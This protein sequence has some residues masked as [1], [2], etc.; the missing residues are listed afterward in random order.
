[1]ALYFQWLKTKLDW[2][3]TSAPSGQAW[4]LTDGEGKPVTAVH[5]SPADLEAGFSVTFGLRSGKTLT[6]RDSR[7]GFAVAEGDGLEKYTSVFRH[8]STGEALLTEVDRNASDRL[9]LELL[10]RWS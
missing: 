3:G 5:R 6:L 7:E 8:L 4:S 1:V 9:F 2:K 10:G